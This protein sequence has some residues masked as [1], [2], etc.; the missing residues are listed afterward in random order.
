MSSKQ[1][2]TAPAQRAGDIEAPAGF[3]TGRTGD[4]HDFDFLEGEWEVV[5]RRLAVRGT[6]SGD[7]EEFPATSVCRRHLGGLANVEEIVFPTRGWAGMTVR[8]FDV[9]KR[10]WAIHWLSSRTGKLYPPVVGGFV[11]GRGEFYGEDEDGGLP[12]RVRFVWLRLG[13]DS[14]RWEQSFSFDGRAWEPN[15]VMELRRTGGPAT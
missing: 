15:W 5:N 8:A 12:V 9:E 14:A 4:P 11:A 3:T 10:Q 13:P 2:A 7:W 6:G 1:T